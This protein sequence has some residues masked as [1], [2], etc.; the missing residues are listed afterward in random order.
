[1]DSLPF[2]ITYIVSMAKPSE[3][4][5]SLAIQLTTRIVG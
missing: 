5:L 4:A 1:M 3:S 2:G